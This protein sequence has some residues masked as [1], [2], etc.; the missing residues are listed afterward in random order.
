MRAGGAGAGGGGVSDDWDSARYQREKRQFIES[1]LKFRS[2]YTHTAL[3]FTVTWLA[4]WLCSW[5]LLTFGV[6]SMPLR[7][8]ISFLLSYLV[9]IA[10]VRHWA[11]YMRAERGSANADGGLDF[12]GADSEGCLVVFAALIVGLLVA[13]LFAMSGGLALLL[14]VAFE[15][16]FAG[17][18][19][20]RLSRKQK[21]GAWL[22]RLVRNTWLHALAT[23]VVLVVVAAVLQGKAPQANTFSEVLKVLWQ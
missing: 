15:V 1:R 6:Q 16:A 14:E 19:V 13:A 3:I 11:N 17:I 4:G 9:F 18:I 5:A 20:R 8:G 2:V 12:A 10:C 7:Y 23:L 21:L 22:G